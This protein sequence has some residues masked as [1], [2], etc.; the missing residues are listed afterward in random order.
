MGEQKF[1]QVVQ[2]TWPRRPPCPWPRWPPCPYMVKGRKKKILFSRTKKPMTLKL[3]MQHWVLEFYPICS[4]DD[5]DL[6][7]GKV[8]FSISYAITG[9]TSPPPPQ[10]KKKSASPYFRRHSHCLSLYCQKWQNLRPFSCFLPHDIFKW[11]T[12]M[13]VHSGE[14]YRTIVPLV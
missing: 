8:K 12:G 6:F 5:H 1:V 9:N 7:Y 14:L 3:G 13:L 4:N 11:L 10:K 2:V